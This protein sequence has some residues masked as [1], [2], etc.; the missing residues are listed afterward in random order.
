M[1][2]KPRDIKPPAR[3]IGRMG[4]IAMLTLYFAPGSSSMA[5][6]IA[7]HEIGCAFEPRPLSF[8]KREHRSPAYLE[9]NPEAKVPTLVID[10]RKLTEVAAILWYLARRHPEAQLLPAA[11][12]D[13]AADAEAEAQVISWMS[14]IASTV[15]PARQRGL[16]HAMAVFRQADTRLATRDWAVGLYSIADIHLFRLYW[17]FA[18]SLKPP[19]GSLPNLEAHHASMMQR[20]AVR[21]TFEIEGAIGYELP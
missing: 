6:H 9:I 21:R 12:G 11:S 5:P 17:R 13:A 14:F 15:H 20:P 19:P 1:A 18:N 4:R 8:A 3:R 16:E 7:L 2:A 10:D